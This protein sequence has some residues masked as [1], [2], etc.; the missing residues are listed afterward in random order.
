MTATKSR[1]TTQTL[2]QPPKGTLGSVALME[3]ERKKTPGATSRTS[4][5]FIAGGGSA[6]GG[7]PPVWASAAQRKTPRETR[8]AAA[9]G[10]VRMRSSPAGD[11]A[12]QGFQRS[13]HRPECKTGSP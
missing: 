11:V 2:L 9:L 6:A 13:A 3:E 8:P 12:G 4:V 5:N 1:K 10:R 7:P